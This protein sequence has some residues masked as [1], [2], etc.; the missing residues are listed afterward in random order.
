MAYRIVTLIASDRPEEAVDLERIEGLT[1]D[2]GV[3]GTK[4]IK[5]GVSIDFH[6]PFTEGGDA[7]V[8]I[9]LG[10]DLIAWYERKFESE[11]GNPFS[12]A[13]NVFVSWTLTGDVNEELIY[14]VGAAISPGTVV[15][16]WDDIEG[17]DV[18]WG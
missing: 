4:A 8:E 10:A 2:F 14:D 9:D 7:Y 16:A 11:T 15:T 12:V 18:S 17:F 3:T 1:R 13:P 6:L 5:P